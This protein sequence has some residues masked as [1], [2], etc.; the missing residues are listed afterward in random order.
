MIHFKY[1]VFMSLWPNLVP[2]AFPLKPPWG[3]WSAIRFEIYD[4]IYVRF[5]VTYTCV[6]LQEYDHFLTNAHI[7]AH[8]KAHLY[9]LQT[10]MWYMRNLVPRAF[11]LKNW[12]RG[13]YMRTQRHR[14][15]P[16]AKNP[17]MYD[18]AEK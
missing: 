8:K 14:I 18:G 10:S 13:W 6:L 11:P 12:G 15:I 9:V 16:S 1:I 17:L 2:R 3:L 7:Y 5:F 4:T